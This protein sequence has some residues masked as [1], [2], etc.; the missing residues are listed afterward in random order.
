MADP[1]ENFNSIDDY[2]KPVDNL[3]KEDFFSK[4]KNNCPSDEETQRTK[5]IFKIFDSKN[6]QDLFKLFCK[7]V[8]IPLADNFEKFL[9]ISN[10]EFDINPL[11]CVS[12]LGYTSQCGMEFT[13]IKIETLQDK[14]IILL[15][16]NDFRVEKAL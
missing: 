15:L 2:Q 4:L 10:K 7:S 11:Y 1:Y 6:W 12:A 3:Q 14:D 9:K 16:E 5:V 13:D 8:V